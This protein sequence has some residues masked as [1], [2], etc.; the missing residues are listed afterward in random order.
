M[1]W[2]SGARGPLGVAG[3]R[4]SSRR[5]QSLPRCPD[6]DMVNVVGAIVDGELPFGAT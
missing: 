6:F 1:K 3:A 2:K 4:R 5:S